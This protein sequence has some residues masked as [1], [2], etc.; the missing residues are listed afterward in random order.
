VGETNLNRHVWS[1]LD[2]KLD[3]RPAPG[4]Q[5]TPVDTAHCASFANT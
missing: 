4:I 5:Q 1:K 3:G 2:L